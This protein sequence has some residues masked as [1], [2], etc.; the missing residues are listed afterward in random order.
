MGSSNCS[1]GDVVKV[2]D[3]QN[4]FSVPETKL[5]D[6]MS[7]MQIEPVIIWAAEYH[8]TARALPGFHMVSVKQWDYI[9]A[10]RYAQN[11]IKQRFPT[12]GY[13]YDW[14]KGKQWTLVRA[15]K[16]KGD[17]VVGVVLIEE[18]EV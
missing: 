18:V 14:V 16:R 11:V 10:K 2:T 17:W 3:E 4:F 12:D 7:A 15:R 1:N 9:N 6:S 5:A 8:V 13:W